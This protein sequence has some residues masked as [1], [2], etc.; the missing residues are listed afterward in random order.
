VPASTFRFIPAAERELDEAAHWYEERREGLGL[1]FLTV[2]RE[3]VFALMDAPGRWRL[4][5]GTRRALL[6]GFPYAVVYREVSDDEI[7]IVAVAHLRRRPKYWAN[8]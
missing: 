8:R 5:N 7:E 4:V 3:K 1:E 6:A 2:V